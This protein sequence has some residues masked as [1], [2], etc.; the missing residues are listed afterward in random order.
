VHSWHMHGGGRSVSVSPDAA[1]WQRG[2]YIGIEVP[3]DLK[4]ARSHRPEFLEGW[5]AAVRLAFTE[6][7]AAGYRAMT[8]RRG[9]ERAY[10]ILTR[11]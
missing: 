9:D 11:G 8:F 6:G 4:A 7:F 5:Q 2:R 10:Y 3:H 1:I